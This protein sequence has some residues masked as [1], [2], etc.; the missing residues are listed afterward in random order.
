[1]RHLENLGLGVGW[2]SMEKVKL[3]NV[4]LLLN[5]NPLENTLDYFVKYA[6]QNESTLYCCLKVEE[7]LARGRHKIWSLSN[8]NWTQTQKHL[9]R[10]R[11][12]TIWSPVAVT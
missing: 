4:A 3:F 8:C 11:N 10:K 9:V 6:Y 1:M 2:F 12:S 5:V 7:H